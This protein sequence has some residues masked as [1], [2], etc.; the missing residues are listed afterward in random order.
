VIAEYVA[1]VRASKSLCKFDDV[2]SGER[3]IKIPRSNGR[4]ILGQALRVPGG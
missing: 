3:S 1:C 4:P 2:K